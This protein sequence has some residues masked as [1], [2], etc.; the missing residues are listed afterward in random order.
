MG[1]PETDRH[2]IFEPFY[3]RKVMGQSGSGLGMAVVWGTVK[4]HNGYIDIASEEGRGTRLDL[5]FPAT[6]DQLKQK[7][8]PED[9]SE[10][11]GNGE[12]ILVVDDMA[13]Q[14]EIATSILQRL[15]YRY[16]AVASGEEAV[17][18]FRQH[19]AD[20]VILDMIMAPGIDGSETY[21]RIQEIRPGQKAII[22]SGYSET[23]EVRKTQSLGAGPYIKKPYTIASIGRVIKAELKRDRNG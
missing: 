14:R 9:L 12:F 3:S 21:R 5:F 23:E 13:I 8:K 6:R 17:D 20:L 18:F 10:I 19:T 1:I 2:R 4:D 22:A 16:G 15:G 11:A 7:Q